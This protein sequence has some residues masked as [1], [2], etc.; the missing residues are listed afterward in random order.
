MQIIQ[1]I[2][3]KKTMICQDTYLEKIINF[4]YWTKEVFFKTPFSNQE[5]LLYKGKAILQQIFVYKQCI[6][7]INYIA[8]YIRL[9]V[10]F[11]AKKL[12]KFLVNLS[13][14]HLEQANQ[15]S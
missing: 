11:A 1:N 4:F 6:R 3:D 5:L 9:D 13:P 2:E 12:S 7:S 8:I 15:T 14:Q 10:L